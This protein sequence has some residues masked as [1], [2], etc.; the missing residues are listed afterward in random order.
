[1]TKDKQF[2][3]DTAVLSALR[4]LTA[5]D[6]PLTV[7]KAALAE[8]S[9]VTVPQLM[10]ALARLASRSL[11]DYETVERGSLTVIVSHNGSPV[12]ES[13]PVPSRKCVCRKCGAVGH[14][15]EAMFCWRCGSELWTA[16]EILR[17]KF[18]ALLSRFPRLYGANVKQADEDMQVL[19]EVADLAF[20]KKGA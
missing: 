13:A 6:Q 1:M 2:A 10:G 15:D 14:N 18:A 5:D 7:K 19:R 12:R 8:R 11:V 20:A 4:G 17:N 3:I 16:E 9:G